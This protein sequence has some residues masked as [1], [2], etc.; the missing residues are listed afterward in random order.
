[1]IA[2]GIARTRIPLLD[3]TRSKETEKSPPGPA[4]GLGH[5]HCALCGAS[6][7]GIYPDGRFD[8][9]LVVCKQ[10]M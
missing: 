8:S 4:H 9:R 5:W 6:E 3:S 10:L 7:S 1:V 2:K